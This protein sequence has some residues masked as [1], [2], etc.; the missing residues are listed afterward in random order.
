[1][2]LHDPIMLLLLLVVPLIAL[3]KLVGGRK[4]AVRISSLGML[5][6]MPPSAAVVLRHVLAILRVAAI[7]LVVFGLARPQ[8]GIEHTRVRTEGIDIQLVVDVSGSMRA[9]DFELDGEKANRLAVV[10]DVVTGF[11]KS[12]AGDRIGLTL[13]AGRAYTQCPLTLDYGMLLTLLEK[14]EIGMIEDGTAIGSAVASAVTRLKDSPSKSRIIVLLTDGVDNAS[15]VDPVTAAQI[16]KTF[17]IKIYAVGAGTRGA[18]PYPM[19]DIFGNT[20]YRSTK[21]EVDDALLAE[22]AETTGGRSFRATDTDSLKETYEEIDELERSEREVDQ[23][24]EHKELFSA[25][26]APALV[27]LLLEIALSQTRFRELP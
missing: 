19:T 7:A 2:N 9:L 22:I 13:F 20:V 11:I 23:Y 10:K 24:L 18:V 17:D 16:A 26:V 5:K 6:T 21:I 15:Q 12:R 1:M 3:G 4:R 8:K 25:F 14:A 27:L